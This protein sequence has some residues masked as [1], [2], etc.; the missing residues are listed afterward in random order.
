M[1]KAKVDPKT[2]PKDADQQ[3]HQKDLDQ[4]HQKEDHR[5]LPQGLPG[6]R[7]QV[8]E[9][10]EATVMTM[11]KDKEENIDSRM[12]RQIKKREMNSQISLNRTLLGIRQ[13]K[14]YCL[15]IVTIGVGMNQ[16]W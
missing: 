14:N 12:Q 10:T 3:S 8:L 2:I 6:H 5:R 4:G 11:I 9:Q 16:R 13:E 7:R 1:T 15:T